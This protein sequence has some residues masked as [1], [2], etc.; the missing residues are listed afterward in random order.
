MNIWTKAINLVLCLI[1]QAVSL[2]VWISG[3]A[4]VSKVQ[5]LALALSWRL[6]PRPIHHW[7][8]CCLNRWRVST[9]NWTAGWR[10]TAR[11]QSLLVDGQPASSTA[12]NQTLNRTVD[13]INYKKTYE[14]ERSRNSQVIREGSPEGTGNLWWKGFLEE[15]GL[16]FERGVKEWRSNGRWE[17]WE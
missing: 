7:T 8:L 2:R 3:L 12:P 13:S 6:W 4:L 14:H 17:L 9:V 11:T 15:I 16:H 5:S 10:C 1:T